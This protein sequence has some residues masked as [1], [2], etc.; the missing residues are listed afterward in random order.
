MRSLEELSHSKKYLY[1]QI[2]AK[3]QII[4]CN[5]LFSTTYGSII[6]SSICELLDVNDIKDIIE[7]AN[8]MKSKKN[9]PVVIRVNTKRKDSV[10][11]SMWKIIYLRGYFIA[12]GNEFE[13]ELIF[14]LNHSIRSNSATIEGLL[15]F[16]NELDNDEILDLIDLKAKQLNKE[17]AK[18]M[19]LLTK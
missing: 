13:E 8:S 18:I 5:D 10:H 1:I 11:L 2:D 19:A 9:N 14:H 12:L 15:Q 3:G 7:V 6:N 4:D 17:I 16:R